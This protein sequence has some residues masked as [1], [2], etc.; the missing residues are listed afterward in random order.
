[1]RLVLAA[2]ALIWLSAC[3]WPSK[4]RAEPAPLPASQ[5]EETKSIEEAPA[6]ELVSAGGMCGSIAGLQCEEGFFCEMPDGQ[7][8]GIADGSGTCREMKPIC[9]RE[10]RPVC[11]CDN[12][13]YGNRC[14]A[15]AAGVSV[16]SM[17]ECEG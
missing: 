10:Y 12:K 17:G 13:T 4:Q 9:T 1:M 6:R 7:C 5:R 8:D 11:G 14:T 15:S 3:L 2:L 16:K